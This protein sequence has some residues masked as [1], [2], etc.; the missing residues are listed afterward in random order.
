VQ[1]E[2]FIY[3]PE[4]T[5]E[6]KRMKI[7]D[8]GIIV[9]TGNRFNV[10]GK[11]QQRRLVIYSL[12]HDRTLNWIIEDT[13]ELAI[14]L[15]GV[16]TQ[17]FIYVLSGVIQASHRTEISKF[18]RADGSLMWRK[19]IDETTDAAGQILKVDET[20][21]TVAV[22]GV[23]DEVT[24]IWWY[25]TSGGFLNHWSED[26]GTF[27][28]EFGSGNERVHTLLLYDKSA[29]ISSYVQAGNG[30]IRV[31]RIA[32][33]GQK[34][35][36]YNRNGKIFIT[37]NETFSLLPSDNNQFFV[38]YSEEDGFGIP[39]LNQFV[40]NDFGDELFFTRYDSLMRIT[41]NNTQHLLHPRGRV[42]STTRHSE[43][44]GGF[45]FFQTDF[46]GENSD[47]FNYSYSGEGHSVSPRTISLGGQNNLFIVAHISNPFPDVFRDTLYLQF[48][49]DGQVCNEVQIDGSDFYSQ[50]QYHDR[51]FYELRYMGEPVINGQELH[52]LQHPMPEACIVDLIFYSGF[53]LNL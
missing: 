21:D 31:L 18:S 48:N 12:D 45:D 39:R 28:G 52:V 25:D 2:P 44:G 27:T 49:Q 20:T 3:S 29:I 36:D 34:L 35:F 37:H 14:T 42:F 32:D 4:F 1:N 24:Y 9:I 41:A 15:D 6:F 8:E 47:F 11:P 7:D 51:N 46:T 19:A 16:M 17:N 26:L 30:A 43:I 13:A 50:V 33:D 22:T 23:V 38:S 53:D 10:I 5:T 40:L